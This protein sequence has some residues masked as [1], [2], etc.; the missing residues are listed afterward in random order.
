MGLYSSYVLPHLVHLTCRLKPN[1]RQRAKVVPQARGLVLEV[2]IGSGLNLPF[3]DGGK[4]T[5]LVGLD[6]SAEM[7]R[8][9]RKPAERT[10]FE[11]EWLQSPVED[12]ALDD[13][14]VDTV[15]V[16]YTLCT[17]PDPD[18]ALRQIARVL[19]PGGELLFCEHGLAPEE[20]VRRWQHRLNPLWKRLAGGCNLDRDIP[21]LLE[22]SGFR[23]RWLETMYLPGW[24]PGT[25]NYWGSVTPA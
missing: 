9:A 4:V 24:R 20:T 19:R 5:R 21:R 18:T 11:V 23:I 12:M 8:M 7:I 17:V 1:M 15:V 25:F 22:R 16:T 2:G 3:Y 14:S 13:R 10:P 6:P